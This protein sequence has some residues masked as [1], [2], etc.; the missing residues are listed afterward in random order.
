MQALARAPLSPRCLQLGWRGQEEQPVLPGRCARLGGK[1]EQGS[2]SVREAFL[3][4]LRKSRIGAAEA[5][6]AW[7]AGLS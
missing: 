2:G 3:G 7:L 5:E 4:W 6:E 1:Q